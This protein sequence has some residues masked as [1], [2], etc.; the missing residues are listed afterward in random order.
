MN[1]KQIM[2][3]MWIPITER[4]PTESDGYIFCYNYKIKEAFVMHA[5]FL[6][7]QL[8]QTQTK[9]IFDNWKGKKDPHIY[10]TG[11]YVSHWMP[12]YPPKIP[13]NTDTELIR[14][15]SVCNC[16]QFPTDHGWTCANGHGGAPPTEDYLDGIDPEEMERCTRKAVGPGTQS[17]SSKRS[18]S[19]RTKKTKRSKKTSSVSSK[20]SPKPTKS[21]RRRGMFPVE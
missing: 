11:Y 2:E 12:I 1:K 14:H 4:K 18:K 19:R 17:G 10:H 9:M 8:N 15:C 13:Q 5:G 20:R 3:E 21:K 7:H 16:R 6:L